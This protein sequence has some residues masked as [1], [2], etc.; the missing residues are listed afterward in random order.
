MRA[1]AELGDYVRAAITDVTNDAANPCLGAFTLS[2]FYLSLAKEIQKILPVIGYG[3]RDVREV[4]PLPGL[5]S[6]GTTICFTIGDVPN[7]F[8][9]KLV[10]F[11]T[12]TWSVRYVTRVIPPSGCLE[13]MEVEYLSAVTPEAILRYLDMR[14]EDELKALDNSNNLKESSIRNAIDLSLAHEIEMPSYLDAQRRLALGDRSGTPD[15]AEIKDLVTT[16][17]ERATAN[18]S[19]HY[20]VRGEDGRFG[21]GYVLPHHVRSELRE[22]FE[23]YNPGAKYPDADGKGNTVSPTIPKPNNESDLKESGRF[24]KG[25]DASEDE[26]KAVKTSDSFPVEDQ[27]SAA[28]EVSV[29]VDVDRDNGIPT[30]RKEDVQ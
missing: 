11:D 3:Y 8:E 13:K 30:E 10:V 28:D 18:R 27:E 6:E 4:V 12:F 22:A 19:V 17:F 16:I 29:V 1:R 15:T 2:A 7:W 21:F 14:R 9:A 23:H 25:P 5:L 24:A 20:L 26:E